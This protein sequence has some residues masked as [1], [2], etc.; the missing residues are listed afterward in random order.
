VIL[1]TISTAF[2]FLLFAATCCAQ[3]QQGNA[4]FEHITSENGLSSNQVNCLYQDSRG[5]IWVGTNNG[6]NR[7][8]GVEMV[9]FFQNGSNSISGNIINS[10]TEDRQHNLWIGT[11]EGV[12]CLQPLTNTFTNYLNTSADMELLKATRF[13]VSLD[14]QDQLWVSSNFHLS[15][16]NPQQKKFTHY[17]I[18]MGQNLPITRN[19]NIR[20]VFEDSKKRLWIPTS[21]G[22]KLFNRNTNKTTSFHIPEKEKALP[23]NLITGIKE[24]PG[25]KI[26]ATTWGVGI[27]ILNESTQQ[28]EQL[29]FLDI[30]TPHLSLTNIVFD[31]LFA[32]GK[33]YCAT[34]E[35]LIV[36]DENK[37]VPGIC[38]NFLYYV[39]DANN[40]KSIS[41]NFLNCLM[42]D[43]SGTIWV[44]TKGISK[45][46][47]LKQQFT[48]TVLSYKNLPAQ[49]SGL[50]VFN[51]NQ[52]LIGANADGFFFNGK[53][54]QPLGF[55]PKI[56]GEFGA[57]VWDAAAGKEFLWLATTNG[58]LQL[59]KEGK[60]VKQYVH[61]KK[62]TSTIAGE[63]LWKVF[64]DS[65]GLVWITTVRKG[66][67]V[68]NTVTGSITNYFNNPGTEHSLFNEYTSAFFEDRQNNIWFS[69]NKNKL[70]QYRRSTSAFEI[71]NINLPGEN[72]I[73]ERVVFINQRPDGSLLLASQKGLL[74]YNP[75]TKQTRIAATYPD[76]ST[77]TDAVADSTGN[78]WMI[79]GNGLL[80][81]N[82]SS[83][84]FKRYTTQNGLPVNE[85]IEEIEL[86]PDGTIL[87]GGLG[88]IT[89]FNPQQ[90]GNNK[91]IP[92][93]YL[94]QIIANSKDSLF[95]NNS[96]RL[97]HLSGIE[98]HFAALGFSNAAQNMYKYRLVGIDKNWSQLT[99]QRSV[100]FAQLPPGNYTFEVM[101]SNA[102]GVWNEVP[103]SFTFNI[104]TPFYKTWWFLLFLT[105][106]ISGMIYTFY[107]YKLKKAVRIATDLHDDIGATLSSI[108]MY[109]ESL[110]TQVKEK[111]PHLEAVLKKMGENSRDM[112]TGMSDIV[113][114]I[115]PDNDS[116]EKLLQR[117]E[118]YAT[119]M[120]AAKNIQLHFYADDK[121]KIRTLPLEKRKNI[122]LI[123][124]EAVNN[125]VKYSEAKNIWVTLKQDAG[126]RLQ[127]KD[128]GKGFNEE[129]VRK[130]NGLKNFAVRAAEIKASLEI[131][132]TPGEGTVIHLTCN[133]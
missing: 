21:F 39:H 88:F 77:L 1:R 51:T 103:A 113:W 32:N 123:F 19:Y 29:N 105:A 119:D 41:S 25:G 87:L 7:Y 49:I 99:H 5:F 120:C 116:G 57:Q 131:Q 111:L 15:L 91:N 68:L 84:A 124:K 46:D 80:H 10:I 98:F 89:Q 22:V 47:P 64:E 106:A 55:A 75:A 23:I 34:T 78:C 13:F 93:V 83:K 58:L 97:P 26:I 4:L 30:P 44:G 9:Q 35:G 17:T 95:V 101:G 126:F 33:L 122:Y 118:N 108:N 112:V 130:G 109:S 43:R 92:P 82:F 52:L 133:L 56:K 65:K 100:S 20:S 50:A 3:I 90:L 60:F 96:R 74:H 85:E 117:M 70:Y 28:F 42:Q 115:N 66:I 73:L 38:S 63:R 128:D 8:D 14:S 110:K 104:A 53:Q 24:T 86:L 81:Y 59:T 45:I 129:E 16:F 107:R 71:Q 79:T 114:A 62:D 127:V 12:S 6:L 102:D 76:M 69:V 48:T 37:L 31:V 54:L 125:A 72:K 61:N 94:T 2:V 18:D 11:N 36:M 40:N 27:L 121:S 67:S 132:S